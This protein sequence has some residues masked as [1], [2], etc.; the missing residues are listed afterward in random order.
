MLTDKACIIRIKERLH[1]TASEISLI[2]IR[3]SSEPRIDPCGA[4]LDTHAG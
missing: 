3:K 1:L 2:Y 4:P